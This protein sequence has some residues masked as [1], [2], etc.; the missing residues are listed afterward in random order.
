MPSGHGHE[1]AAASLREARGSQS[2]GGSDQ[3]GLLS[4]GRQ[5]SHALRGSCTRHQRLLC[6]HKRVGGL[7]TQV[8]N[9]LA[10]RLPYSLYCRL[11]YTLILPL[12]RPALPQL[13]GQQQ[14]Q[15]RETPHRRRSSSSP[16]VVVVVSCGSRTH[17]CD[18]IIFAGGP[19][20][21]GRGWPERGSRP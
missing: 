10:L 2:Q 18:H 15:Q 21:G 3:P 12:T 13:R 11:T 5:T 19:D 17:P 1:A 16:L 6:C 9:P 14:Q 20:G 8:N 7:W 4:P